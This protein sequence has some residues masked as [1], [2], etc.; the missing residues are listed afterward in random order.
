[1]T[2]KIWQKSKSSA[3]GWFVWKWN[4]T[5]V[6]RVLAQKD[7]SVNC[8]RPALNYNCQSNRGKDNTTR[9]ILS[10]G[11]V[12]TH[13]WWLKSKHHEIVFPTSFAG[14]NF[15][16]W[17]ATYFR[18]FTEGIWTTSGE[19]G[20]SF[21]TALH[22]SLHL[23]KPEV[24]GCPSMPTNQPIW[25]LQ[26]HILC[27]SQPK[28]PQDQRMWHSGRWTWGTDRFRGRAMLKIVQNLHFILTETVVA[29]E[30]T[31]SPSWNPHP[32]PHPHPHPHPSTSIRIRIRCSCPACYTILKQIWRVYACK[33]NKFDF[34]YLVAVVGMGH[35]LAI[36]PGI[37]PPGS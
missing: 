9:T 8:S 31:S 13:I 28:W 12:F 5:A 17:L 21:P 16:F 18:A 2:A 23:A 29:F 10:V 1:M 34:K 27:R 22:Y 7:V 30:H 14:R 15:H 32:Q 11:C 26:T 6:L 36:W 20:P 37:H 25:L 4:G 19:F 3:A 35:E 33:L 24:G